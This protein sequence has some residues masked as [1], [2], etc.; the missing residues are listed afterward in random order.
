MAF[1]L[2]LACLSLHIL[3][4]KDVDVLDTMETVNVDPIQGPPVR[5]KVITTVRNCGTVFAA[6]ATVYCYEPYP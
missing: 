6:S 5:G 4:V 2:S 3:P 1:F